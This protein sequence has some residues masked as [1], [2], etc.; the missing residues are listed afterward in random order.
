MHYELATLTLPFGTAL[1][2]GHW[3][4]PGDALRM[5]IEGVGEIQHAW[6]R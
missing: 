6:M 5:G 4:K 2:N 1:E 3:L